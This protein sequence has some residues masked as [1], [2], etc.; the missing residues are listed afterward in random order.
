[1]SENLKYLEEIKEDPIKFG[2]KLNK[3][4]LKHN[5]HI[6][7]KIALTILEFFNGNKFVN[8]ND[9]Q[10]DKNIFYILKGKYPHLRE[11]S[12]I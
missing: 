6:K 4:A 9:I 11:R 12:L 3:Y 1:M 7:K 5:G 2:I 8:E 10:E